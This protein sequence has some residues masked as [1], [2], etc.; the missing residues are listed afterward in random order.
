M[1]S[2]T[3]KIKSYVEAKHQMSLDN[4]RAAVA[5]QERRL[6]AS[7]QEVEYHTAVLAGYMQALLEKQTGS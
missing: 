1:K 3:V 6:K 4:L 7:A 5:L 2:E